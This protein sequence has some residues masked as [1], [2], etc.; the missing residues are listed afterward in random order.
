MTNRQLLTLAR[1]I[2]PREQFTVWAAK[3][4]AGHGRRTGS[5]TLGITEDA[6]RYRLHQAERKIHAALNQENAA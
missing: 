2:L 5:L 3:H 6:W 1:E 4:Y